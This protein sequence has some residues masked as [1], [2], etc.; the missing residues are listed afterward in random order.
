MNGT[1]Q[2]DFIATVSAV[3]FIATGKLRAL[4]VTAPRR[5]AVLAG[6]PTVLEQG[7]PDLVGFVVRAG[8]PTEIIARLNETIGR[9]LA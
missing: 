8:T 6:V 9:A 3:D 7:F 1:I 5:V 2:F 4:A